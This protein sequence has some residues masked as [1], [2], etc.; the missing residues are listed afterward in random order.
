MMGE[1][2]APKARARK[3]PEEPEKDLLLFLANYGR[4]LQDW[5][6]DILAMVREEM[7]YFLPQMRTKIMNEGFR[8]PRA[9]AHPG[10]LP[11]QAGEIWE[12]RRLHSGVLS[13]SPSRMSINPYYVGFQMLKDIERRWDGAPCEGDEEPETDWLG[14]AK[15]RPTGCGWKKV[16]RYVRKK[17]TLL[18][19]ANT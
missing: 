8:V 4:D 17:M 13:P 12:F 1:D 14:N 18:F 2:A 19:C 10:T 16:L 3:F 15:P 7:L 6:R 9:R 11:E 5:Q